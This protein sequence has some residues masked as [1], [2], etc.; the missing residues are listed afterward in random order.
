M[1]SIE[2]GSGPTVRRILLDP[3]SEVHRVL[4]EKG[5]E[6]MRRTLGA[7]FNDLQAQTMLAF[8]ARARTLYG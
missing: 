2:P 7:K 8:A 5:I 3:S 1:I 4:L 6:M